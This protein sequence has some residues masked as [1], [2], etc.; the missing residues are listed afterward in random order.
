MAGLQGEE[1][2]RAAHGRPSWRPQLPKAPI[3]PH[4]ALGL[5]LTPPL[6]LS[7]PSGFSLS[8][9]VRTALSHR[10]LLRP[11]AASQP[12]RTAFR[13]LATMGSGA[14]SNSVE[15]PVARVRS[16]FIDFFRSKGERNWG[17]GRLSRGWQ[18][19]QAA[20]LVVASRR[21]QQAAAAGGGGSFRSAR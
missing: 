21:R 13:V 7:R 16:A 17:G 6:M 9:S 2:N 11:A 4:T 19:D 5:P 1:G 14:D 18:C 3:V 15:W 12:P 8:Q 20:R 10:S